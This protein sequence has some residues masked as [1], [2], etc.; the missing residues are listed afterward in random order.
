MSPASTPDRVDGA[1]AGRHD[2]PRMTHV[3]ITGSGDPLVLIHGLATTRSIWR[4]V[5]PRLADTRQVVTLDVPGFGATRPV[6]RGFDLDDVAA[7]VAE[8]LRASAV[9]EP[10]DLVGH[11]MG[12]AVAITLAMRE[13]A[14]VRSLVLVSP[15]GLRPIPLLG[16][17]ALGMAAELYIPLRRRA[18]ALAGWSWGRRLLMA[19]G[20]VDAAALEPAIVRQLVGA[21][22]GARR[23]GPALSTVASADLRTALAELPM[24]VGAVWGRGDRVIPPGGVQTVRQLRPG[25]VCEIVEGAGHISM[26]EQPDAFVEALERVLVAIS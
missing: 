8:G 12:A 22:D 14:A 7:D 5:V 9:S 19:G 10:Y 26:V 18:S 6:G 24:P 21:S 3:D 1:R 16:A 4:H 15:A 23:I 11:S 17:A 20:V 25:A 13:P 2:A